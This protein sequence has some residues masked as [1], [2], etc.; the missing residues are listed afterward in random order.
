[1]TKQKVFQECTKTVRMAFG[2][3]SKTN[4]C[5]LCCRWPLRVQRGWMGL[6]NIDASII[7]FIGR[8][9]KKV[10]STCYILKSMFGQIYTGTKHYSKV[11][12]EDF[13]SDIA[14]Q[15]NG[16]QFISSGALFIH[17]FA[18]IIDLVIKLRK[19]DE[20]KPKQESMADRAALLQ[21]LQLGLKSATERKIYLRQKDPAIKL[22]LLDTK[23]NPP[24]LSCHWIK[25]CSILLPR[26]QQQQHVC[27]PTVS[28]DSDSEGQVASESASLINID[29]TSPLGL[30]VSE[31]I[32]RVSGKT[33]TT[34]DIDRYCNRP[35]PTE[36]QRTLRSTS[37]YGENLQLLSNLYPVKNHFTRCF[38]RN[39][40][41]LA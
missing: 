27:R 40:S 12:R 6:A 18:P 20:R 4:T 13:V 19:V 17:L 23:I 2:Q 5:S 31:S 39:T 36:D 22:E 11:E 34:K 14:L 35:P 33:E 24:T 21:Y 3:T 28:D 9:L 15:C 37:S 30:L 32:G 38:I 29:I 26:K 10:R 7:R 25:P 41:T 16:E 8:F 1:M